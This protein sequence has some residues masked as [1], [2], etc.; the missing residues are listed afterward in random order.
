MNVLQI[1]LKGGTF[2]KKL[3]SFHFDNIENH[4]KFKLLNI[5]IMEAKPHTN[6]HKCLLKKL[7][8]IE[9]LEDKDLQE[10][11]DLT[12]LKNMKKG[13]V[14][15]RPGKKLNGVMCIINGYAKLSKLSENGNSQILRLCTKGE[16]LG[17]RSVIAE[18]ET[19]LTATAISKM[20]VCYVPKEVICKY[21][22]NDKAFTKKLLK[23]L[24][25]DLKKSDNL[26]TVLA[27]KK[28][29]QRVAVVLIYLHDKYGTNSDG[30]L[31][32]SFSRQDYAE[33]TGM[34]V[35]SCI[36]QLSEFKSK[37]FISYDGKKIMIKNYEALSNIAN[38]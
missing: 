16:L 9:V 35:E 20:E 29:K 8:A 7:S 3:P 26:A 25:H 34:A 27:Q 21:I 1:E 31:V 36:R 24:A 19:N 5:N 33:A 30:S 12:V 6:C 10:I 18:E 38:H 22:K 23:S 17:Q 37:N 32:I 14:I 4:V 28:G 2:S 13:D 15:Y 11:A